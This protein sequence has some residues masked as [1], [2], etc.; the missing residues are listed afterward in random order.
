MG[1]FSALKAGLLLLTSSQQ[2]PA[3][4]AGN[5][6][7]DGLQVG[8]TAARPTREVPEE[9]LREAHLALQQASVA[10]AARPPAPPLRSLAAGEDDGCRECTFGTGKYVMEFV[11]GKV[12]EKCE[13]SEETW[14]AFVKAH[15]KMAQGFL[16]EKVRP[17]ALGYMYCV[18]KGTCKADAQPMEKM[19]GGGSGEHQHDEVFHSGGEE[20]EMLGNVGELVVATSGRWDMLE[21]EE[22]K[23]RK[24]YFRRHGGAEDEDHHGRAKLM[25]AAAGGAAQDENPLARAMHFVKHVLGMEELPPQDEPGR[26]DVA[27][28]E[29]EDG[30]KG[31]GKGHHGK[32]K[33]DD[34]AEGGKGKGGKG[35]GGKGKGGKG[36]GG[37]GKGDDKGK[38]KG[39][40]DFCPEAA[41]EQQRKEEAAIV[42]PEIEGVCKC[43]FRRLVRKVMAYAV[44]M[45]KK[46][47]ATTDKPMI[48][49]FCKWGAEHPEMAFGVLLAKV[50]PEKYALIP[51]M[52][53]G[54]HGG[55]LR[56]AHHHHGPHVGEKGK[57]RSVPPPMLPRGEDAPDS[58]EADGSVS[59]PAVGGEGADEGVHVEEKRPNKFRMVSKLRAKF[60]RFFPPAAQGKGPEL[61]QEQRQAGLD[62]EY[63][64]KPEFYV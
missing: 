45:T 60:H 62:K 1:R 40:D 55:P 22:E 4:V 29:D 49:A 24:T 23:W 21:D 59:S 39:D 54:G 14:C 44:K 20:L 52:K 18:G 34:D 16:I 5:E 15:P 19:V 2:V 10:A 51:C 53:R 11:W 7:E 31:K 43:C 8:P 46:I 25:W 47:C 30:E 28:G 32:G 38:G 63:P 61:E 3:E 57:G 27:P 41:T 36:K 48:Q 9:V 6:L 64:P 56:W 17:L 33:G 35:K 50:E 37:K 26:D 58:D 12:T 42:V 13:D